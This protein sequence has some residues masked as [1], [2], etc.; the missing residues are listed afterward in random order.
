[1]HEKP[2]LQCTRDYGIFE[3]HELNRDLRDRPK[4]LASMKEHGFMPSSPIQCVRNGRGTLKVV[5]GHHRLDY[6]ERL[7]LPVWYVVDESNTNIFD[8]EGDSGVRWNIRDFL[9]ARAKAGDE[10]CAKVLAFQKK[11]QLTQGAAISLLGGEAVGSDNKTAAVKRGTF[12]V[13]SDLK[14]AETVASV[15]DLC[16]SVGIAFATQASFV[17][18][19]SLAVRVPECDVK[20][21]KHRITQW[22][23][24]QINK[25]ATVQEYLSE[26]EGLYNHA[27]RGTRLPLAFR[28]REVARSR[29]V[30]SPKG[31]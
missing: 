26:I 6:A 15:T 7:K 5:R 2:K 25:R 22:G 3:M 27:A 30:A 1:M 23:G 10:N 20:I 28:A 13:C 24:S 14:H 16:R 31:R 4:L 8:L 11:H 19:V 18:A 9:D 17:A 21:L 29:Q 12:R